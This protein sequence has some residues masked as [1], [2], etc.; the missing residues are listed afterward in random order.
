MLSDA[1][2]SLLAQGARAR[3]SEKQTLHRHIATSSICGGSSAARSTCRMIMTQIS[4]CGVKAV[5]KRAQDQQRKYGSRKSSLD[6]QPAGDF[7]SNLLAIRRIHSDFWNHCDFPSAIATFTFDV[8]RCT[9]A[10]SSDLVAISHW[11]SV[12]SHS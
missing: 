10:I 11:K 7:K 12:R 1:E 4:K 9:E 3:V 5:T 6:A 2:Q 8:D